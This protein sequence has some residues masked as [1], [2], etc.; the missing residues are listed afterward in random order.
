M[1]VV[2]GTL[3]QLTG[4]DLGEGLYKRDGHI[5]ASRLGTLTVTPIDNRQVASVV[6]RCGS[7]NT[8]I[9]SIGQTILGT[10]TRITTRYTG[11]DIN[12]LEGPSGAVYFEEPFKGTLR[13][14]DIW[15]SED[16]DAPTQMYFAFRPG[17]LV[18]ARIIG[19][20][21]ASAGFLLSTAIEESLGVVFARCAASGE[22]LVPIS[23]NEMMC[24]KTGIKEPRKPAKP[25]Q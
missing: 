24:A 12:V 14:Q 5:Y 18:R 16:K 15:P 21:D 10:V 9:P 13:A 2:P 7:N 20:G 4:C 6:S 8:L 1:Q 11:I 23:W 19:V 17:D 25:K 22:P 3:V